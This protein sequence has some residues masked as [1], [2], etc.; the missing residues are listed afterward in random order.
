MTI[1][2]SVAV[3]RPLHCAGAELRVVSSLRLGVSSSGKHW[4][5]FHVFHHSD[6]YITT[7][8]TAHPWLNSTHTRLKRRHLS[9]TS[10]KFS[11]ASTQA[12]GLVRIWKTSRLSGRAHRASAE[13]RLV[14]T[15]GMDAS[16]DVAES[17]V[18]DPRELQNEAAFA[19]SYCHWR[20]RDFD[21]RFR[22]STFR[23]YLFML[24]VGV[25]LYV[26]TLN[27]FPVLLSIP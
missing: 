10:W 18:R 17:V 27:F 20:W 16:G 5:C 11:F 12:S 26:F 4:I 2:A 19:C 24:N 22:I 3:S 25:C 14:P 21:L 15:N 13:L 9:M 8:I 23:I 1:C 6:H 7:N